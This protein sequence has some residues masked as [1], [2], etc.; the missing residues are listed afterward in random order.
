[1]EKIILFFNPLLYPDRDDIEINYQK[2]CRSTRVFFRE[3]NLFSA[4][5]RTKKADTIPKLFKPNC[6]KKH[7]S[8]G[9][10]FS[11]FRQVKRNQ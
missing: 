7:A 6:I 1:M 10:L 11:I 8:C 3:R 5:Q 4:Y 2:N 9:K